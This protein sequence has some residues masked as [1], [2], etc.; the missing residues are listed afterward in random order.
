MPKRGEDKQGTAKHGGASGPRQRYRKQVTDEIKQLAV[1]QLATGGAAALSLS[2]IAA[3]L[4]FT[5][6][7]LYRYFASRDELLTELIV[8]GYSGMADAIEGAAA[9]GTGTPKERLLRLAAAYRRWAL[10]NPHLYLLVVGTPVPGY[11]APAH[12]R[13][14]ARRVLS[15]FVRVFEALLPPTDTALDRQFAAWIADDPAAHGG[16]P[17]WALRAAVAAWARLHGLVSLEVQGNFAGMRFDP[18]ALF[19]AEVEA[20]AAPE[21]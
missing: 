9:A 17:G 11:T 10:D 3:E 7:A 12:T 15:P 8:D 21:R 13:D 2:A 19:T 20:L 6:P 16:S 14:A 5:T 1:D 4:G 18:E